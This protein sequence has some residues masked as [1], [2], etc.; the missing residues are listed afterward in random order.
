MQWLDELSGAHTKALC[1]CACIMCTHRRS[2]SKCLYCGAVRPFICGFGLWPE[3]SG[4]AWS[5]DRLP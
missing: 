4:K 3:N 1:V 5:A 2:S